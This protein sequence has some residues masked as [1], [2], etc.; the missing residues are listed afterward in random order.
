MSQ[1]RA[2]TGSLCSRSSSAAA[3]MQLQ[4]HHWISDDMD[5]TLAQGAGHMTPTKPV[6]LT[7]LSRNQTVSAAARDAAAWYFF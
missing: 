4:M 6:R 7:R 5:S 3:F 1:T 2:Q